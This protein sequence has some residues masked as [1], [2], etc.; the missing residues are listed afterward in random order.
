MR[1]VNMKAGGKRLYQRLPPAF[2]FTGC[3]LFVKGERIWPCLRGSSS[4][5]IRSGGHLEADVG[6]FGQVFM[7]EVCLVVFLAVEAHA[8]YVAVFLAVAFCLDGEF[9]AA[10]KVYGHFLEQRRSY[11][12]LV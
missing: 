8:A 7:R 1:L 11:D 2:M 3:S 5:R 4:R 9:L 6:S 10:R 12:I